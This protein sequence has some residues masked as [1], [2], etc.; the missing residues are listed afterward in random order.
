PVNL[1]GRVCYYYC[2]CS[3]MQLEND[4]RDRLK[5]ERAERKYVFDSVPALIWYKDTNNRVVKINKAASDFTG[6]A[7]EDAEG[8][9][10]WELYPQFADEYY[11]NDLEVI[12][13]GKV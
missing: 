8:K 3:D 7:T 5:F 1:N 10:A 13:S 6:L 12:K 2:E 4:L 9:N 11:Q